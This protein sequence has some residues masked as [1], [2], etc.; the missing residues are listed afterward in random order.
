MAEYISLQEVLEKLQ[1][2]ENKLRELIAEGKLRSFR[3]PGG[4]KF[5]TEQVQALVK[6]VISEPTVV[7][8]GAGEEP[9][10]L[11]IEEE[12]V[13][14]EEPQT[15][16]PTI[17]L[18]FDDQDA[19]GSETMIPTIELS[20]DAAVETAATEQMGF[21]DEATDV[22][23]E[24][25]ALADEDYVILEDQPGQ[26]GGIDFSDTETDL[27]DETDTEGAAAAAAIEF[28]EEPAAHTAFTVLLSLAVVRLL[29]GIYVFYAAVREYNMQEDIYRGFLNFGDWF[30]M[31]SPLK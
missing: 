6:E 13:E 12:A 28:E 27:S 25:V 4:E 31:N 29:A 14:H 26:V 21:E 5:L 30:G 8:P 20:P 16:I 17:E 24:E 3:D 22:A 2:S 11:Q 10:A 19:P 15:V 9:P 1:I 18:S 7:L 23:T